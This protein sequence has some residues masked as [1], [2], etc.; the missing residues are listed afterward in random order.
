MD[1]NKNVPFEF[2]MPT[3]MPSHE[4][5]AY[6]EKERVTLADSFGSS[7]SPYVTSS[8]SGFSS[9]KQQER[10]TSPL[11][12]SLHSIWNS[13]VHSNSVR[14]S[15]TVTSD[16]YSL[17]SSNASFIKVSSTNT[18][19][20]TTVADANS[21]TDN[22]PTLSVSKF[23]ERIARLKQKR[24]GLMP[25]PAMSVQSEVVALNSRV[26]SPL[27]SSYSATLLDSSDNISSRPQSN[28][29]TNISSPLVSSEELL[30]PSQSSPLSHPTTDFLHF[31]SNP[32]T[33]SSDVKHVQ[34]FTVKK[35]SSS[36]IT[37]TSLTPTQLAPVSN[38]D[39][40]M[41]AKINSVNPHSES[42]FSKPWSS[43]ITDNAVI[44][45]GLPSDILASS[46]DVNHSSD[47]DDI[48]DLTPPALPSSLPPDAFESDGLF[49]QADI[50]SDDMTPPD[51]PSVPPPILP[52]ATDALEDKTLESG[53]PPPLPTSPI[54]FEQLSTEQPFI[55]PLSIEP[56]KNFLENP[57]E[58]GGI[59]ISAPVE[60]T[61]AEVVHDKVKSTPNHKTGLH[62]G[63]SMRSSPKTTRPIS[64]YTTKAVESLSQTPTSTGSSRHSIHLQY[65]LELEKNKS[66]SLPMF[67]CQHLV[68]QHQ[69]DEL[70]DGKAQKNSKK[71]SKLKFP[72]Q[73]RFGQDRS[74]YMSE[75]HLR[76]KHKK[77]S[78]EDFDIR[79]SSADIKQDIT[80]SGMMTRDGN[81]DRLQVSSEPV[82]SASV[83]DLRRPPAAKTNIDSLS[84]SHSELNKGSLALPSLAVTSSSSV[85]SAKKSSKDE[86]N[87][88]PSS[89]QQQSLKVVD[90]M[91][92][93]NSLLSQMSTPELFRK[94]TQPSDPSLF[95]SV[96]KDISLFS[97]N[98]TVAETVMEQPVVENQKSSSA[99]QK[100][101]SPNT[102]EISLN[103]KEKSSIVDVGT[104]E[105]AV[106]SS[107]QDSNHSDSLHDLTMDSYGSPPS[108][109]GSLRSD[110]GWS[111][112]ANTPNLHDRRWR[113]SVL[114]SIN[115]LRS[116]DSLRDLSK[117]RVTI[118]DW[119]VD[120]V[121]HW[122]ESV[123]LTSVVPVFQHFSINGAKLKALDDAK[124]SKHIVPCKSKT[125]N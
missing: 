97:T 73:K 69:D 30:T 45:S 13:S 14:D 106:V 112:S 48:D 51:L 110:H 102:P 70:S 125:C 20:S 54:P 95:E 72:W 81:I 49:A 79:H 46:F 91:A 27:Q 33:V 19:T 8:S 89:N 50:I 3:T 7:S 67:V 42:A 116:N 35:I 85:S 115:T 111:S 108:P 52:A 90:T 56:P 124:L 21:S 32:P 83:G 119:N 31:A 109:V 6:R 71:S 86:P 76:K 88:P 75:E 94:L 12:T 100:K 38:T 53:L 60:F 24:E 11:A 28:Y 15:P 99:N 96:M 40:S 22:K 64:H 1:S 58:N 118:G 103:Q 29:T 57:P 77:S 107:Q 18:S 25:S 43:S 105:S 120:H 4:L 113:E 66:A 41:D 122:L 74:H 44:L 80:N 123:G 16:D 84:A 59:K 93:S 37:T 55:E 47:E 92:E 104:N 17:N 23:R 117:H 61:T 65:D 101:E 36:R 39:N 82:T 62:P 9:I 68:T 63:I 121:I 26:T 87:V 5:T 10:T 114:G 78:K 2:H 34:P 98:T